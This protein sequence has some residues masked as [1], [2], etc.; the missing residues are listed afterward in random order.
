MSDSIKIFQDTAPYV[1]R[2]IEMPCVPL[3]TRSSDS[4]CLLGSCFTW[5]LHNE[6]LRSLG[7]NSFFQW[8]TGFHFST[9]SLANLM[10]RIADGTPHSEEDLYYYPDEIG[11]FRPFQYYFNQR[12]PVEQKEDVLHQ[13]DVLDEQCAAALRNCSHL[14]LVTG[15]PRV[16][17]LRATGQCV[18]VAA[19]MPRFDYTHH[20]NSVEEEVIHLSRVVDSVLRI[21]NGA[22]LP[23]FFM[24][25]PMRYMF[26]PLCAEACTP[27]LVD[28]ARQGS[29]YVEDN[30][31]KAIM[32]VALH[33]FLDKHPDEDFHYFPG[34]EL[35]QDELRAHEPFC[36]EHAHVP[37]F[38]HTSH[39]VVKR[40]IEHYVAQEIISQIEMSEELHKWTESVNSTLIPAQKVKMLDDFT[41]SLLP[42]IVAFAGKDRLNSALLRNMFLFLGACARHAPEKAAEAF[43][44]VCRAMNGDLN[45][46]I[47]GVGGNYSAVFSEGVRVLV[48]EGVRVVLTDGAS[49][50]WGREVD[51]LKVVAPEKLVGMNLDYVFIASFY[52][53]D[54][55]S[56]IRQLGLSAR[57]A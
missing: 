42:R 21:R 34:F 53:D 32:R 41:Q 22:P 12:F 37:H 28:S 6:G 48:R 55:H 20:R 30:L 5:H 38:P 26:H 14:M 8:A 7:L 23:I 2:L 24:L 57:I 11:G 52:H 50:N 47:W 17:R 45:I 16:V 46:A 49:N 1:R 31:G 44:F 29:P 40:F 51:G 19:K 13:L 3:L 9:E 10:E 18:A 15:T 39:Y 54:I 36:G 25:S 43:R 4:L 33:T 56:S 35:V 27:T